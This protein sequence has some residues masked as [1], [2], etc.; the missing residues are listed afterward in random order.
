MCTQ[1]G[2]YQTSADCVVIQLHKMCPNFLRASPWVWVQVSS[3]QSQGI[4]ERNVSSWPSPQQATCWSTKDR[5]H[6]ALV[7]RHRSYN[8]L[9]P[10]CPGGSLRQGNGSEQDLWCASA[11]DGHNKCSGRI[12]CAWLSLPALFLAL[13]GA[14]CACSACL[15]DSCRSPH[16][17]RTPCSC[18]AGLS[19]SI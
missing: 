18:A 10:G 14:P 15:P 11:R 12:A 2:S 19:S 13:A 17:P 3:C 16:G 9:S 1:A 5:A 6:H 7:P 4:S 8:G